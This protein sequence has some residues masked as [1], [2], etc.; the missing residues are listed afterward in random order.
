VVI[1]HAKDQAGFAALTALEEALGV[2][3]VA[4]AAVIEVRADGADAAAAAKAVAAAK[5]QAVLLATSGRT[6]I[7]MLKAMSVSQPGALPLMQVYGLSSA[8]S[9]SELLELSSFARGFSMT[10]V[11]PLPRD[12][13]VPMVA[14]FLTAMRN[15]PG[16]RTYA[17]LEGCAGPLLLAEV[18]RRKPA[19]PSRAAVNN[20]LKAAG[21][22]GLGGFDV[23]LG[24]RARSGS[25]FTDI[26]F[27]GAD[28]RLVR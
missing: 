10:Q 20:A 19:E 17:E 12:P 27:V 23:D 22:V 6:T 26:V 7:A 24:D 14:T 21:K 25:R 5:P 13:R 3:D 1:V 16:E 9:Q 15:A 2:S 28:G 18:L 11:L 8:A 4:A